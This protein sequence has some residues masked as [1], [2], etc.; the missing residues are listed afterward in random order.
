MNYFWILGEDW[1]LIFKFCV[2]VEDTD[3]GGN[4]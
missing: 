2:A 1:P 3:D 4:A